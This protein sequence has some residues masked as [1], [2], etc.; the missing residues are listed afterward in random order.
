MNMANVMIV[1]RAIVSGCCRKID[2]SLH[3]FP[4]QQQIS[5][6]TPLKLAPL[7]PFMPPRHHEVFV[8]AIRAIITP[9]RDDSIF[10]F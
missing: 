1:R 9:V 5:A 6:P 7:Q 3:R 4:V 8:V 10:D 2:I